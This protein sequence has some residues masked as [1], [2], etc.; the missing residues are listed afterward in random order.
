MG[1]RLSGGAEL[2]APQGDLGST[3]EAEVD[4]QL[5]CS[6]AQAAGHPGSRPGF[7]H[8]HLEAVVGAVG[9]GQRGFCLCRAQHPRQLSL[10]RRAGGRGGA[11]RKCISVRGRATRALH[12][13][14]S[15][16]LPRQGHTRGRNASSCRQLMQGAEQAPTAQQQ[17]VTG[18][19]ATH[20]H[21][22][23][24]PGG[25]ARTARTHACKHARTGIHVVAQVAHHAPAAGTGA[26]KCAS[27]HV[28]VWVKQ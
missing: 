26:S 15:V 21:T 6:G 25:A 14:L 2:T 4:A 5:P 23:H 9:G 28:S 12:S 22:S 16:A 18:I 10:C 13:C 20:T 8:T 17:E 7:R 19:S 24:H 3:C 1:G 27:M 11:R